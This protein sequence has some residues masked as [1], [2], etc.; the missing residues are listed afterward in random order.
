[1]DTS[2][3]RGYLEKHTVPVHNQSWKEVHRW[4]A[5]IRSTPSDVKMEGVDDWTTMNLLSI[6]IINKYPDRFDPNIVALS[7]NVYKIL[8]AGDT[9]TVVKD[10]Y[11]KLVSEKLSEYQHNACVGNRLT[12]C[13]RYDNKEQL[14]ASIEQLDPNTRH[15]SGANSNDG[16]IYN[17]N[18]YEGNIR[19][20]VFIINELWK[21]G[22]VT[23]ELQCIDDKTLVFSLHVGTNYGK[24]FSAFSTMFYDAC[25]IRKRYSSKTSLEGFPW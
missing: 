12:V 5:R 18:S 9:P 15:P 13:V 10:Y 22:L 16:R 8:T 14:N 24:T 6:E 2:W 1:M 11:Q 25:G 7:Q 3:F 23:D 17:L 21:H 19:P 4:E 20:S